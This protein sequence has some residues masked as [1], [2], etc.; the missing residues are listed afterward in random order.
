MSRHALREFVFPITGL[1]RFHNMGLR[2]LNPLETTHV[3]MSPLKSPHYY[4]Y[5]LNSGHYYFSLDYSLILMDRDY[6]DMLE[7]AE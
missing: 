1:Q 5:D 4:H 2:L 6:Q 3:N 7:G